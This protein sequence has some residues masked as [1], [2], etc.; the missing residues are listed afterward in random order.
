MTHNHTEF[1]GSIPEIYD[2]CLGPLLFDFSARDLA[3]RVKAHMPEEGILL[4]IACGTGISTEYLYHA[5]PK[6]VSILASDLN[7][8]MLDFAQMNRPEL[9]GV[10]FQ[11]ANAL[12][13]PF[14]DN[15]FDAVACQ[16]GI[17]FFPDKPAGLKEMSRVLKPGGR[18]T[19]NVWDSMKHN[20]IIALAHET[21]SSFFTV[22]PPSFLTVPFGYHDR[23][24]L[25]DLMKNA[26][27]DDIDIAVVSE[28]VEGSDPHMVAQGL[29]A[30]NP[31]INEIRDRANVE[32]EEIIEHLAGKV[33]AM[34]GPDEL[35]IPLR[36]IVVSA[37]KP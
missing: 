33:K 26:G 14:V 35:R 30:G 22:E 6:S 32:P 20:P 4:E 3:A 17:M 25:M 34:F 10:N 19:F 5:L 11:V 9:L 12:D 24:I 18:M 29:V 16:F 1:T 13:L 27:Y 36:E 7:E 23:D 8:K 2:R 21:I 15:H 37:T 28:T 31:G